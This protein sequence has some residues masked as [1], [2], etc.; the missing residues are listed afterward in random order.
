MGYLDRGNGP[1]LVACTVVPFVLTWAFASVRIYIRRFMLKVW[2]IE[3]WLFLASQ[4]CF[5]VLA[6]C[7]FIATIYGNGQHLN[8]VAESDLPVVMK[9]WYSDELIYVIT[10]L[11][12]RLSIGF[13]LLRL[14]NLKLQILLIRATMCTMTVVSVSYFGFMVFQCQPV[15]YFWLRFNGGQGYCFS[16][17]VISDITIVFSVVAAMVDLLFGILPIFVIWN[18]NMNRRAKVIAGGLL[19][20][21]II[22][23]LSVVIRIIY[24]NSLSDP[25][26]DFTFLTFKVAIWSI[27]EPAIG[28]ICMAISTYRPL[29]KSLRDKISPGDRSHSTFGNDDPNSKSMRN[30][31]TPTPS[32]KSS[33]NRSASSASNRSHTFE[34][35]LDKDGMQRQPSVTGGRETPSGGKG[36]KKD[37]EESFMMKDGIMRKTAL[38]DVG[39]LCEYPQN[40]SCISAVI[41][42]HEAFVNNDL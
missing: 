31:S 27:I 14:C 6:V 9:F 13:F 23:G 39:N 41:E 42:I 36:G 18:L 28:I 22:A 19:A 40:W 16:G 12:I 38:W 4:I 34:D 25:E 10:S 5:S 32:Q 30:F 24:I 11:L 37:W 17:R 29:F 26:E 1:S 33:M 15:A 3:D 2:K 8:T 35:M 21:G 20:L 7:A